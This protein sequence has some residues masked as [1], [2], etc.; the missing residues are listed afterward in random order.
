MPVRYD[1]DFYSWT[2]EQAGHLKAGRFD[3]LDLEHLADEVAD[4][5]KSEIREFSSRLAVI[6]AHLLK[7][8]VQSER[9]GTNER[10]WRTTIETQRDQLA[11]HLAENPGLKNPAIIEKVMRSAWK[12]GRLAAITE[13]GLDPRLFP[14]RCPFALTQLLDIAWWPPA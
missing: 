11:D 13:M 4:M 5:G 7:L 9:T 1:D 3:L 10:S 2:Q 12:D 14:D 6:V 8:I